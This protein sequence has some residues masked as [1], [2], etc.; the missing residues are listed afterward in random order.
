MTQIDSIS[1]ADLETLLSDTFL[2]RVVHF[3]ETDSTSSRAVEMLATD[4]SLATPC[5]VHA[6]DQCA[7]R[8]RGENRWWSA[9]GSLTFS[10][11]IDF[12]KIGFSA[13]DKPLLPLL[14]GMAIAQT[15]ESLVPVGDFSI[16]WPNDVYLAGRK[17]AGVLTEVPSQAA[18]NAVIGVG[19]NVNNQYADAPD[20]L[21][22]TCIALADRSGIKHN[23]IA[24]L[25]TF[26]Q[27]FESLIHSSE[28]RN[29]FLDGWPRYC[30]LTGKEVTLHT[31]TDQVTGSCRGVDAEGALLLEIGGENK[32]FFGGTVQSWT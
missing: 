9:D 29:G 17:L 12:R 4:K 8:G 28:D 24:V 16:K 15:G 3:A 21:Q 6:E 30:M 20:Q 25:R 32:R 22:A 31:G 13:Q 19:L 5:L 27:R 2:E 18:E 1:K 23:R 11:I 26:L 7:G 10:L 14:T